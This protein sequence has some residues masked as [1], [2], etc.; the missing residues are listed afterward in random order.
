MESLAEITLG[1]PSINTVL[2]LKHDHLALFSIQAYSA[3]LPSFNF[4]YIGSGSSAA[5]GWG[6]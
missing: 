2:S 6:I 1:Q 4:E 3:I 5:L